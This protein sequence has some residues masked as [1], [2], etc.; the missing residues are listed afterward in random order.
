MSLFTSVVLILFAFN[1]TVASIFQDQVLVTHFFQESIYSWM[2]DKSVLIDWTYRKPSK[3]RRVDEASGS[4]SGN[5]K[6]QD[7]RLCHK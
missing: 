6:K 2:K 1:H 4:K 7:E 5:S 3:K